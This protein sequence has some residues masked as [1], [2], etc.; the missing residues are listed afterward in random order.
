M[1]CAIPRY[2]FL[3]WSLSGSILTFRAFFGVPAP[4]ISLKHSPKAVDSWGPSLSH[5]F[6]FFLAAMLTHAHNWLLSD[7]SSAAVTLEAAIV[8]SYDSLWNVL[9]RGIKALHFPATFKRT[10][11]RAWFMATGPMGAEL[12]VC[13]PNTPLWIIMELSMSTLVI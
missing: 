6:V 10:V 1:W 4:Q 7:T 11:I 12:Q 2:G 3:N 9:F 8:G 5:L 13:S